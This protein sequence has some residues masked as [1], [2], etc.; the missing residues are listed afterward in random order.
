MM[1]SDKLDEFESKMRAARNYLVE[2]YLSVVMHCA[3]WSVCNMK[4]KTD[5]EALLKIKTMSDKIEAELANELMIRN[6]FRNKG[7][8]FAPA[9]PEK[10]DRPVKEAKEV[11][12]DEADMAETQ[13]FEANSDDSMEDGEP[14]LELNK[15]IPRSNLNKNRISTQLS[16][17]KRSSKLSEATYNTAQQP[18]KLTQSTRHTRTN[19][20][21][22]SSDLK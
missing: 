3:V 9:Q 15:E 21:I 17:S 10:E 14:P 12:F 1:M 18:T 7:K 22:K 6:R 20:D 19:S 4:D 13:Y 16:Q 11:V 5:L 2:K 8:T